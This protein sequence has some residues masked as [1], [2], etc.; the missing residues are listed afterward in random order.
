MTTKEFLEKYPMVQESDLFSIVLQ[1][2]HMVEEV[3]EQMYHSEQEQLEQDQ[4]EEESWRELYESEIMEDNIPYQYP[5]YVVASTSFEMKETYVFPSNEDGVI[6]DF[7]EIAA[8]AER[9]GDENWSN[10]SVVM[11]KLPDYELV[12]PIAINRVLYKQI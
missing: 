11:Q 3:Y 1:M 5:E 10:P 8:I 9:Y 12:K 7:N 2:N 6:T 4:L